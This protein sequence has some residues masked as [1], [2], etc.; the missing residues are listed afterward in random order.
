MPRRAASSSHTFP[1]VPPQPVRPGLALAQVALGA[2]LI[3]VAPVW[4]RLAPVG[5]TVAGFYRMLV[6]AVVLLP[7]ALARRERLWAGRRALGFVI[8]AS[9]CFTL[10]LVFWHMS[11]HRVGPGL[12][13]ILA[14]FQVFLLA[15][16]GLIVLRE[17]LHWQFL[18]AVPA[19]LLGLF[20]LVGVNWDLLSAGYQAGVGLGLLTALVYGSYLLVLRASQARADRLE[21]LPNLLAICGVTAVLLLPVALW[22]GESLAVPDLRTGAILVAYGITAQGLGWLLISRGIPY[23]EATRAGLVLLLQPAL[24]FVWD[25]LFFGRPTGETDAV[26]A[27]LALSAIYFGGRRRGRDDGMTG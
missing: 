23:V 24:A 4:V 2:L 5:P 21:P 19:A 11:I 16:F 7:L 14:N 15:A 17:R 3:S 22:R 27:L 9:V 18:V 1:M 25:I 6:G 26:G 20:L 12:A 13:T 10:D 8:V